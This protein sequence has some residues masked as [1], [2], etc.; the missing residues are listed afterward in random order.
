MKNFLT[1]DQLKKEVSKLRIKT[2]GEYK[3]KRKSNWPSTP[4]RHYSN[5]SWLNLFGKEKN[6]SL[7]DLTIAIRKNKIK[8]Y[9]D[10]YRK[11][12]SNWPSHPSK[13]Y[14]AHWDWNKITQKYIDFDKLRTEVQKRKI[15][16]IEEY[17]KFR[18]KNWPSRP[19]L[20]YR[21]VWINW[22][23]FLGK[24]ETKFLSYPDLCVQVRKLNI[25]SQKDYKKNRKDTWPSNP[26]LYYK[27]EWISWF[28][29]FGKQI[30]LRNYIIKKLL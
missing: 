1:F 20:T 2:A 6:I 28:S 27:K 9:K 22:N 25:K 26:D 13:F 8:T 23:H 24:K 11:K 7:E 16:S 14:K 10:Y 3:L 17:Q 15:R 30:N 18:K 4:S 5:F 12:K 29:L 19:N 21:S